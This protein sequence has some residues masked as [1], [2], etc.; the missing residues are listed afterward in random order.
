MYNQSSSMMTNEMIKSTKAI[1]SGND[2][3]T[4]EVNTSNEAEDEMQAEL[5]KTYRTS[6]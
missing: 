1:D 5:M 2:Q 4:I 3:I 6:Y